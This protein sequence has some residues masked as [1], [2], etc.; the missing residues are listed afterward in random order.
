MISQGSILK[1]EKGTYSIVDGENIFDLHPSLPINSQYCKK[2]DIY[3]TP[4]GKLTDAQIKALDDM[5]NEKN[6]SKNIFE[7]IYD[8]FIEIKNK[9]LS[10]FR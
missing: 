1:Y 3:Y 8:K 6:D 4:K 2:E 9:F 5:L 7:K 10:L